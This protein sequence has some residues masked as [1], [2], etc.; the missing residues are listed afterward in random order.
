MKT[1]F[2]VLLLAGMLLG[3]FAANAQKSECKSFKEGVL[4][5]EGKLYTFDKKGAMIPLSDE[6][7]LSNGTRVFKTG[8]YRT[9]SGT[10][11][12]LRNGEL[13]TSKGVLMLMTDEL[14]TMDGVFMKDGRLWEARNGEVLAVHAA[15]PYGHQ[16]VI[17]PDGRVQRGDGSGFVLLEGEWIAPDGQIF[18]RK[19]EVFIPDGVAIRQGK[20]VKWEQ[21]RYVPLVSDFGMG[22]SGAKV[23]P[24]GVVHYKDGATMELGEGFLVSGKGELAILKSELISDALFV[25]DGKVWSLTQGRIT[26][27]QEDFVLANGHIL[28]PH[29][30]LL[31]S[32]SER[33]PLREGEIILPN[34][35]L[36][37][38]KGNNTADPASLAERKVT[39]HYV[40]RNGKVML[41]RN[42]D[43]QSL[44]ADVTLPNGNKLTKS[45]QMTHKNGEKH[46]LKEG[47]TV[48]MEGNMMAAI[49]PSAYDER[50]YIAMKMG[51]MVQ[52][53]DGIDI[54]LTS[55]VLMP[56]W[57]RI[58]PDGTIEKPNG[59]KTK[60]KEGERVNMEGEPMARLNTG[61]TGAPLVAT[62]TKSVQGQK[63]T[64]TT[65]VSSQTVIV[66]RS[67]KMVIQ[68]GAKE[69]MMSKER[70]LNNGTKIMLN[71]KVTRKDGS[72][73]QMR[74]GD[75]IDYN[76]GEPLK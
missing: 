6:K 44:V 68:M 21:G 38:S 51:R 64:T 14:V 26:P 2:T 54:S 61:Y 49:P 69:V 19:D 22:A 74:E 8:E 12:K 42:G 3:I 57:S 62:T 53:K 70:M 39:D 4:M 15:A 36:L 11:S 1:K 52:V 34:G 29:G 66:M 73:F 31:Y 71:G 65:A 50:N 9:S 10:R 16:M 5:K 25:R 55:D 30:Q 28:T 67:G 18:A 58:Y 48:N 33:M 75:K 7:V 17:H 24:L 27:L 63:T 40:M 59:S 13:L 46:V 56:D 41:V 20:T 23:S 45:G 43:P 72:S 76:S 47:E 37:F 32:S 35:S 60:L